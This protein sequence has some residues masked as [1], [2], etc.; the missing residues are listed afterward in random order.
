[1]AVYPN[2]ETKMKARDLTKLSDRE[3]QRLLADEAHWADEAREHG[4]MLSAD[5]ALAEC[6]RIW[7][8]LETRP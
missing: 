5:E 7:A 1:M 4:F 6:A 2:R 3:L 8:E